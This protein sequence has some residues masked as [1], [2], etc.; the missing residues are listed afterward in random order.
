MVAIFFPTFFSQLIFFSVRTYRISKRLGQETNKFIYLPLHKFVYRL[1]RQ[2]LGYDK[3]I[4]RTTA[5]EVEMLRENVIS[6]Q[7]EHL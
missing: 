7:I 5:Y 1:P 2:T 4:M 3:K 6:I